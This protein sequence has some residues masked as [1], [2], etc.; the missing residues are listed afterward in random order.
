MT[1]PV[2]HSSRSASSRDVLLNGGNTVLDEMI[3]F[4]LSMLLVASCIP[5]AFP[6]LQ[7]LGLR[8]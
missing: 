6:D 7:D 4:A 5:S 1:T 3:T 8:I 2:F